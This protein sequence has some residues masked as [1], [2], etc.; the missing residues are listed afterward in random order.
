MF[1]KSALKVFLILGLGV[2]LVLLAI[3]L[4]GPGAGTATIAEGVPGSQGDTTADF[5]LGQFDFIHT[6][7]NLVDGAG[8][9]TNSSSLSILWGAVAIDKSA[10]PNIRVYVADTV[11]NRVLGFTAFTNNATAKIVIGQ[12]DFTS[13]GCNKPALNAASLCVPRGVAVDS[14]GNLYVA[15]TS[16]NRVLEYPKP[17]STAVTAGLAATKV[18]GQ[19]TFAT[20]TCNRSGPNALCLPFGVG[21]DPKDNLYVA[22]RSNSRV[23]LYFTPN[24]VT[25]VGGS[26]NTTADKV[27]GQSDSFATFACNTGGVISKKSLCLPTAVVTDLAGNLFVADT[28]NNR[29]L[30]F[31]SPATSDT[32]ADLVFGQGNIFTTNTCN[33]GGAVSNKTLCSPTGVAVDAASNVYIADT[34]NNRILEYAQPGILLDTGA[35][36]VFGQL[37]SFS[38]AICNEQGGGFSSAISAGS[39]CR[40]V[41]VAVDP[42][43]NLYAVDTNNNR[44]F[45]Y[46]N[47]PASGTTADG[48]LGQA[49]FTTAAANFVD[50]KGVDF[51]SSSGIAIDRSVVPNRVYI[52]DTANNRVLAWSSVAAAFSH[53]PANLVFGQTDPF[54]RDCNQVGVTASSLCGPQGVALDSAGNL[55]IADSGNSRVLEYDKPFVNGTVADRVFGQPVSLFTSSDCNH[56]GIGLLSLCGPRAVA[57]DSALNLYVADTGNNRVLA[58]KTPLTTDTTADKVLGQANGTSQICAV[59]GN[60]GLCTPSGVAVDGANNVYVADLNNNRV[61]EYNNPFAAGSDTLADRVFGQPDFTTNNCDHNGLSA[62]SLC[63]ATGVA[64]SPAGS[65]FIADTGNNRVLEY[66]TPLLSKIANRVFGQNNSFITNGCAAPGGDSLCS[67][68]GVA[69]DGFNNLYVNDGLSRALEYLN[70]KVPPPTPTPTKTPTKTPTRTPTKTPA[71]TPTKT[72]TRTPTKTATK[73]PTATPTP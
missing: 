66:D 67:P 6:I 2:L 52:A 71:K 65:L 5:V 69:A 4:S 72:P 49:L 15:D 60:N 68:A 54:T 30:E 38:T 21:L 57:V 37:G 10:S 40:P 32:S 53:M 42:A 20:N 28:S 13:N 26:G 46:N 34:S 9:D 47:P 56:G 36:L 17:F 64:V 59:S 14:V 73:K 61:L 33:K 23:L 24:T 12:S 62:S 16:N 51:T 43:G 39:L 70:P 35:D 22:D 11:N 44:V 25:A 8:V 31:L 1:Q 19:T 27:L 50:G 55:Y 63:D 3:A 58:Y 41:G 7:P 29:A 48:V 45:K 18:F